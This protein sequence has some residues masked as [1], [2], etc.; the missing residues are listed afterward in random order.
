MQFGQPVASHTIPDLSQL[1]PEVIGGEFSSSKR[2]IAAESEGSSEAAA[3]LPTT[4][5]TWVRG[6]SAQCTTDLQSA[7]DV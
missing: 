7:E 2:G 5:M 1:V 6:H 4:M 3:V